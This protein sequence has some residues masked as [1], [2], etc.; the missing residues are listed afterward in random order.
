[1][2]DQELIN[3]NRRYAAGLDSLLRYEKA[4]DDMVCRPTPKS[5]ARACLMLRRFYE[6]YSGKNPGS[7][8]VA[9]PDKK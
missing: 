9:L 3:Y 6:D 2:K 1:M 7:F 5:Y 4:L 8:I